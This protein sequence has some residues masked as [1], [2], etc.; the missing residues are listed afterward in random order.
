MKDK[1]CLDSVA[2]FKD[3]NQSSINNSKTKA[4]FS[5]GKTARFEDYRPT[6]N[7]IHLDAQSLLMGAI[8]NYIKLAE[9]E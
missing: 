4:T 1:F 6:Y 3:I 2:S 7:K 9:Q 5:F 8:S